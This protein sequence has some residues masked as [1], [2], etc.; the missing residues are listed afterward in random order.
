MNEKN[1]NFETPFKTLLSVIKGAVSEIETMPIER[2]D[3]KKNKTVVKQYAPVSERV[4]AFRKVWPTGRIIT[5]ILEDTGERATVIAEVYDDCGNL[6]ATGHAFE[7]RNS[8]LINKSSYLLNCETSAVGRAIA[9]LGIGIDAGIASADE[10]NAAEIKQDAIK[11]AE[12]EQQLLSPIEAAS[13][14]VELDRQ[15][16]DPDKVLKYYK[17]SNF[18]EMTLKSWRSIL[19]NMKKAK[20]IWGKDNEQR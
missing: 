19:D 1:E 4:K 12:L 6:L 7:D 15:G 10:T 20:E 8:S 9:F 18:E 11:K 13:F 16:I 5:K 3:K 2:F 14:E 17:I